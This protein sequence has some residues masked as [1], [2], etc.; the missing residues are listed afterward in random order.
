M[1]S[2]A[3][4][5]FGQE[6]V[7]FKSSLSQSIIRSKPSRMMG[8]SSTNNSLYTVFSLLSFYSVGADACI[9]PRVDASIDPYNMAA[10]SLSAH[11]IFGFS[12]LVSGR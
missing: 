3:A 1:L 9:R 2:S 8:S 11:G 5:A 6:A 10:D 7:I 12:G 4:M